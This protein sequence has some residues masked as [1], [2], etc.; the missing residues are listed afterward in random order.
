MNLPTLQ[1]ST[2]PGFQM[3][4]HFRCRM[5]SFVIVVDI[6]F[7]CVILG[8]GCCGKELDWQEAGQHLGS[9]WE[10]KSNFDRHFN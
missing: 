8:S 6:A 1:T 3:H 5:M 4:V 2:P 10:V 7:K 9:C